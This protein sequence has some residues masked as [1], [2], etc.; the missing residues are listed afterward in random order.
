MD[1]TPP[2]PSL[3]PPEAREPVRR[4][5]ITFAVLFV[6]AIGL[7]L[8][9]IWPFRSPLLLSAVLASVLQ[10][11]FRALTRLARG[12]RAV[13]G[14]ATTIALLVLLIG[15][16][17]AII[18]FAASQVVKGLAFLRDELGIEN[19]AQLRHGELSPRG[20]ELLDRLL[21]ALHVTR[22][23]LTDF[24]HRASAGAEHGLSRVVESSGRATFHTAIM[25]IAFYFFLVE[26]SR[27][28]DYL[29]RVSPLEARQTRDLLDEFRAVSRAS[30][31]G[32]TIAALFQALTATLGYVLTGVPH[33][34]FFGLCTLVASFIP[35]IGT[36]LVW[37]PAVAFLWLAGHHGSALLLTVWCLVF[38]VG[39]EHIGKPIVLRYVL[40]SQQEMHT[41]IVFLALLGGLEMFGLIGLVLGPLVFAFLLAMLRIYERDFRAPGAS[42]PPD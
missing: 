5:R 37:L 41:G 18:A 9:V 34:I 10:G 42:A 13:A 29:R 3:L 36:L 7:A 16:L 14:A 31:L 20:Q 11:P 30:I 40:G 1:P 15:P 12:R 4:M 39:A 23:Q 22:A 28:I 32:T 21:E 38:V 19:V 26:G 2:P 17:A 6:L 33:A 27:I 35:V 8:Y 25:L 24:A